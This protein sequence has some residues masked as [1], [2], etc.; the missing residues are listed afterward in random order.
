MNDD[1]DDED[2]LQ[3]PE[4]NDKNIRKPRHRVRRQ[5]NEGTSLRHQL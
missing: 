2:P 4:W 1:I 3:L 5:T